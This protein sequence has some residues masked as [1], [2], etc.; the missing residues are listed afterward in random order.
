MLA[1]LKLRRQARSLPGAVR[2]RVAGGYRPDT[3]HGRAGEPLRIVF[4]REETAPCSERVVFPA[5]GRSAM[6]PAGED[7]LV[8]LLPERPGEYEFSCQMGMLRGRIVVGER[9]LPLPTGGGR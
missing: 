4:R 5:F 1:A 9:R 3:V 7:V 2:V 6:L 8:E